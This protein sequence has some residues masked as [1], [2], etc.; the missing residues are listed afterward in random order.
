MS[1]T[2]IIGKT[3]K[4]RYDVADI[5][6]HRMIVIDN[7]IKAGTKR[8]IYNPMFMDWEKDNGND[9]IAIV[10]ITVTSKKDIL[11]NSV[12]MNSTSQQLAVAGNLNGNAPIKYGVEHKSMYTSS[13][14]FIKGK[15]QRLWTSS[16]FNKDY[17][18]RQA[19]LETKDG[20]EIYLYTPK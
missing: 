15:E 13:K 20:S 14:Y 6:I 8:S 12:L 7:D 16:G 19:K 10:E 5:K 11:D 3:V 2:D 17:S 4:M 9:Y 1:F 18:Y